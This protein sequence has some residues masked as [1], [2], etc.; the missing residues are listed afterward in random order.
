MAKMGPYTKQVQLYSIHRFQVLLALPGV[1]C[2]YGSATEL[3][4]VGLSLLLEER[5]DHGEVRLH[6]A[7]I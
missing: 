7:Y 5:N 1:I 2:L 4:I 3:V 6:W